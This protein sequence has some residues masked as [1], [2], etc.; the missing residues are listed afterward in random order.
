MLECG[1]IN[2]AEIDALGTIDKML[3]RFSSQAYQDFWERKALF[4]DPQWQAIRIRASEVLAMLPNEARESEYTRSVNIKG[5][6][7]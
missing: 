5:N 6:G 2:Q 4:E 3:S 7:S 1:E